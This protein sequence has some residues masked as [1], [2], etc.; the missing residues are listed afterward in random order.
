MLAPNVA[1]P[2]ALL[3][4]GEVRAN[5]PKELY[6]QTLGTAGLQYALM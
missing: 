6:C 4:V 5:T 2:V 1:I 3:Q